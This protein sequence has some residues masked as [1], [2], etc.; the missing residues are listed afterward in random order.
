[1][2]HSGFKGT[3]LGI[4]SIKIENSAVAFDLAYLDDEGGV[5]GMARH[6]IPTEPN[7]VIKQKVEELT[8]ALINYVAPQHFTNPGVAGATELETQGGSRGIGETLG[9]PLRTPDEPGRP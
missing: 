3:K 6:H 8:E 4:K 7:E 1:M 2:A 5:H 9:D